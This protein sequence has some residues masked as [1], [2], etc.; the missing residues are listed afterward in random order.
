M[1]R[2][3]PNLWLR[4]ILYS[5]VV[6]L[7]AIVALAVAIGAAARAVLRRDAERSLR[8][9]ALL[10]AELLRLASR[11]D[12]PKLV[13]RLDT[14]LPRVTV[15][16]T[17]GRVLADSRADPAKM[18]NHRL[19]PEVKAALESGQGRAVHISRTLGD[20]RLYV[21]VLAS[22]DSLGPL[23]IRASRELG[24]MRSI[25]ADVSRAVLVSAVVLAAVALVLA[26]AFSRRATRPVQE[27]SRAA[28][29]L[30]QGDL[31]V[32]VDARRQDELGGLAEAFNAMAG[33]L[34][35]SLD[36][37]GREKSELQT[38]IHAM[39]EGVV[40]LDP[41]RRVFIANAMFRR[42]FRISP[43]TEPVGRFLWEVVRNPELKE[44]VDRLG[45]TSRQ[46]L[47]QVRSGDRAFSVTA[48][49][50]P[51]DR[52]EIVLVAH[53]ITEARALERLKADFIAN[54]SHELRTPLTAI[55]GYTETIESEASAEQRRYLAIVTRHTDRLIALVNDLLTITRLESGAPKLELEPVDI[56]EAVQ[57]AAKL[58][59]RAAQ[60]KGLRIDILSAP[61][62]P[63]VRGDAFLLEQLVINLLDNA[64]KYTESGQ[65]TVRVSPEPD[66]KLVK[67][68]VSD[69]GPGIA[70]EHLPRI[71]ERFYVVDKN[72][73]R[74]LGG[75]GLGLAIVK[76]I[77][78]AH[79]GSV[80]VRSTVGQGTTFTVTLPAAAIV[81]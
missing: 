47:A 57:D 75:T 24:A 66:P 49:M 25:G 60:A 71:F 16:D 48:S 53:D 43:E 41:E 17:T 2:L 29:R 45:P 4:Q 68:E 63:L 11:A 65:V 5:Y 67:L 52:Q 62:A 19:R 39:A 21:A 80:S 27:L 6:A 26:L 32:R 36:K 50:M 20:E 13:A 64:V 10:S 78:L 54:V 69:T 73:S 35:R 23:V 3:W 70:A 72:R 22:S 18:A 79:G 33:Q 77:C 14:S 42:G 9:Q 37:L 38:I 81:S 7:V 28:T 51:G 44:L 58:L 34:Q 74:E 76:H 46:V 1:R 55:K 8:T 61:D 56:A 30:A 31:S 12:L 40:V 15:I 59:E